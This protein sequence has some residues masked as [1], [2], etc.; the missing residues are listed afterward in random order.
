M[1]V[2]EGDPNWYLVELPDNE[3]GWINIESA[4]LELNGDQNAITPMPGPTL[5]ATSTMEPTATATGTRTPLDPLAFDNRT[6]KA[7]EAASV[8]NIGNVEL[9]EKI[10]NISEGEDLVLLSGPTTGVVDQGSSTEGEW[11]LVRR[12]NTSVP[13]GWVEGRFLEF[14]PLIHEMIYDGPQYVGLLRAR[15]STN[16][17]AIKFVQT[18]LQKLGYSTGTIDGVFGQ[19][20]RS[21]VIEF[22]TQNGLQADGIVGPDTWSML[23]NIE[24]K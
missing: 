9:G 7:Q 21:A 2:L 10:D 19:N 17:E 14:T 1:G 3:V 13:L 6:L 12:T 15:L 11:Y 4:D 23:V 16:S 20:T 18:R 24:V 22:Q 8:W 5:T